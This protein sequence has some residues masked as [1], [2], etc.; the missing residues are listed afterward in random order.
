MGV[1]QKHQVQVRLFEEL[2]LGPLL[3]RLDSA[4]LV[5]SGLGRALF[6]P[7]NG[8]GDSGPHVGVEPSEE[9]A[10][11]RMPDEALKEPV[12]AVSRPQAIPV[13][14]EG[15]VARQFHSDRRGVEKDSD[16][17]REVGGAPPVVVPPYH[18]DANSGVHQARECPQKSGV[19]ARDDGLVLEP[20]VEDV[21]VQYD[22]VGMFAGVGEPGPKGSLPLA[23]TG[24]QVD[25]A[26]NVDG[27]GA[28]DAEVTEGARS[29]VGSGGIRAKLSLPLHWYEG[30]RVGS[31]LRLDGVGDQRR[32]MDPR[33]SRDG[34]SP[35][36][37]QA[38]RSSWASALAFLI[39]W[40]CASTPPPPPIPTVDAEQ[41]VL[42]VERA[43]SLEGA[44]R[45]IFDWSATEP[46]ARFQGRGVAR[47][48]APYLARLDLFTDGGESVGATAL[49]E[50]DVRSARGQ[51]GGLPPP[52][53]FWA[54]L[55]VFRPGRSANLQGATRAGDGAFQLTYRYPGGQEVRFH[56]RENR[57]DRIDLLRSGR[58][59]EEIRIR[60]GGNGR[61]PIESTYR[62]L[63]ERREL[64]ITLDTTEH[65]E[66][67]PPDIWDPRP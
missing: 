1:G 33:L 2:F 48:E 43:T 19:S 14:K 31:V 37:L 66:S 29:A 65:V 67:F 64:R 57:V 5:R 11:S 15:A 18:P 9:E 63:S 30:N 24:F 12:C 10:G 59:E 62:H 23:G 40:G 7:G 35:A 50:D 52:A 42:A 49:V 61:F 55:G 17:I 36:A 13:G 26:G 41:V 58:V 47:I 3:E 44:Y 27:T 39:L 46:D 56:L 60:S 4:Q 6:G 38:R 16:L 34:G 32:T 54:A 28:H 45:L 21:S 8:S 20:E 51:L 53:L 22:F 25:I